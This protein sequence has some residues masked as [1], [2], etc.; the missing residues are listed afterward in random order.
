M[1]PRRPSAPV[2]EA[3]WSLHFS[4]LSPYL[5]VLVIQINGRVG[6]GLENGLTSE[7]AFALLHFLFHANTLAFDSAF[8]LLPCGPDEWMMDQVVGTLLKNSKFRLRTDC[9]HA[10]RSITA[11]KA[12]NQLVKYRTMQ[13]G[14]VRGLTLQ[15]P[16][17][18]ASGMLLAKRIRMCANRT[19]FVNCVDHLINVSS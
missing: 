6:V 18:V 19:A 15:I 3:R 4:Q 17:F 1:L 10:M 13:L 9:C 16:G 7:T 5:D 14:N 8:V 2:G 12:A 11:L